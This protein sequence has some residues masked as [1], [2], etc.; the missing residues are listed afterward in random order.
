LADDGRIVNRAEMQA[1]GLKTNHCSNEP[2]RYPLNIDQG[3]L[4]KR[5]LKAGS[6]LGGGPFR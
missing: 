4:A 3:W 5:G 6:K 2:V 1:L